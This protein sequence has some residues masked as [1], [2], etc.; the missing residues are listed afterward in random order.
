MTGY[1]NDAEPTTS[2]IND[3]Q[4]IS[5]GDGAIQDADNEISMENL[6]KIVCQHVEAIAKCNGGARMYACDYWSRK[7][8]TKRLVKIHQT[9]CDCVFELTDEN[10]EF[11]QIV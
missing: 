1:I 11:R 8:K 2:E 5:L 10:F 6:E 3:T 4:Q 7:F 9:S